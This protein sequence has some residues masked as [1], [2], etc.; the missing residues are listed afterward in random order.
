MK[1]L[2]LNTHSWLEVHQIPKLYALAKE[3]LQE[4][5]DVV[6]LQEVNQ[7]PATPRDE[8][9]LGLKES[10]G[11]KIHHDNFARL[12]VLALCQLGD[13]QISWTWAWLGTHRGFDRYDEGVA[14]LSR[15]GMIECRELDHGGDYPWTDHR[16]RRSLAAHIAGRWIL[17]SHFSWWPAFREE[18][19]QLKPQL[20]DLRAQAPV[21]IA[22]DFNNPANRDGEGYSLVLNDGWRDSFR[23]AHYTE[24]ECTVHRV[25]DGWENV[26]DNLRIDFVF[27]SDDLSVSSYQ[28]VFQD[29]TDEAVSDHSGIVVEIP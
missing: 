3:I 28:V 21:I 14:V 27:I 22:G 13:P 20:E 16:R 17:S 10:F 1:L 4:N 15:I 2:T 19:G 7:F 29:N 18:W 6:V 8:H 23:C 25:I 11:R 12:L 24:G 5:V 9:P 26:A